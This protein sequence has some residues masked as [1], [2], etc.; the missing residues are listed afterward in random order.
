[1]C[2]Q[3][4]F[5]G[6]LGAVGASADA[7]AIDDVEIQSGACAQT[8]SCDFEQNLWGF[9]LLKADFNW[10]RT[11]ANGE[12]SLGPLFDHTTNSRSGLFFFLVFP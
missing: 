3:I 11:S 8:A 6:V 5:E 1:M 12:L 10:K 7:V 9:Q 4:V 2:F